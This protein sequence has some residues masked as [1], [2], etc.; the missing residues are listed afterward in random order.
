MSDVFADTINQEG[1][2]MMAAAAKDEVPVDFR[3]NKLSLDEIK[4][5]IR[6]D[7]AELASLYAKLAL[8]ES[9][10][11]ELGLVGANRRLLNTVALLEKAHDMHWDW[12]KKHAAT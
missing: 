11:E 10:R 7:V 9:R 2:G 6:W 3:G 1:C 4:E 12:Y 8:E 5:M